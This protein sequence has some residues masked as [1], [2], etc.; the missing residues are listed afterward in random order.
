LRSGSPETDHR[1]LVARE[2]RASLQWRVGSMAAYVR[3]WERLAQVLKRLTATG[4]CQ[5]EAKRDICNAMADRKILLRIF[6]VVSPKNVEWLSRRG[7]FPNNVHYVTPDEIPPRLNPDDFDWLQSRVWK[8]W[9]EVRSPAG[10]FLGHW[11]L[12]ERSHHSPDDPYPRSLTSQ[13]RRRPS[14]WHRVE[15]FRPD[16]TKVLIT[17]K[18]RASHPEVSRAE[19]SH[20]QR[21]EFSAGT[22]PRVRRRSRPQRELAQRAI[23]TLYPNS[24][25]DQATVPNKIL[26]QQAN[27]KLE[28]FANS[29]GQKPLRISDDTFLRAAGRRK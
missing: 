13:N 9:T 25:P 29:A 16:V 17:N 22:R 24:V 23:E 2:T 27:A 5:D 3:D 8:P 18:V 14:Y 21:E 12:A 15:L 1:R 11:L 6:F 26:C 19:E 10:S 28:E 4:V 7:L 20:H